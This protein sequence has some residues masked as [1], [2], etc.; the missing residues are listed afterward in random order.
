MVTVSGPVTG[1]RGEAPC[2]EGAYAGVPGMHDTRPLGSG[3]GGI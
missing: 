3:E 2:Q 1:A